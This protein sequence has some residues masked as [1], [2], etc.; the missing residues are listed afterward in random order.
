MRKILFLILA[1]FLIQSI[2]AINLNVEKETVNEYMI[3][4]LN[5][6]AVFTLTI[7]NFGSPDSFQFYNL[8]G[9]SMFPKGTIYIDHNAVEEVELVFYP[10][11]DLQTLGAY[12]FNYFIRGQDNSETEEDV[13]VRIIELDEVFEVGSENLDPESN[14][15]YVFLKN[16]VNVDFEEVKVKFKSPFFEFEKTTNLE[17]KEKKEFKV[18]LN[19]EDFKKLLAGFYTLNA[20]I[21]VEDKKTEVEGTIKFS[22]K[23]ILTTERRSYGFFINTNIIEKINEGNVEVGSETV[24]KKNI[25]TRLFTSFSPE[26]DFVERDGFVISYTW[27]KKVN[28]GESVEIITRTNWLFPFLVIFFIVAIVVLAKQ[29]SM[30]NVVLRK[31]V[32]FVRAKCGEFALKVKI[33][34]DARKD[35][36]RV[37]VFDKLPALVKIYERFGGEKPTKINEKARRIE[38][39]FEKL[40]KGEKRV[41]SYVIYSKVGVMGKFELPRATAIYDVD[42]EIKESESNRAYFVAEQRKGELEEN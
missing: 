28:P 41:L 9:F 2:V 37:S 33:L 13:T 20:E 7:K 26:P 4:D 10:R 34:V 18:E 36:E 15:V 24:V 22:E 35:V 14:S 19:K 12:N 23:D 8:L 1:V 29:Y 17:P 5:E 11:E 42:G 39:E 32:S 16:K 3:K 31:K 27:S 6:P 25:I 21:E 38:W 40:A 30:T